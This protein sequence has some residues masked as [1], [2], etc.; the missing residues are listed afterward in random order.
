[1]ARFKRV[2]ILWL[3]VAV[4]AMGCAPS[5]PGGAPVSRDTQAQQPAPKRITAAVLGAPAMLASKM[6]GRGQRPAPGIDALEEL[7]HMG[8]WVYDNRGACCAHATLAESIPSVENGL[9]KV[10]PDG[11]MET[12]WKIKQGVLWHDGTPFTA[13][14]LRFTLTAVRDRDVEAHW[15]DPAFDWIE[16]VEAPDARTV[17]LRWERPFIFADSMFSRFYAYP[18]PK[19][20]LEKV[21]VEDKANFP[22]IR[23]WSSEFIGLGPFKL[24]EWA[25]DSHAILEA[26][27]RY[28]LGRP[29]IDKIEV[30]FIGDANTMVANILAG[31]IDVTLSKGLSLEQS[32]VTRDQWKDGTLYTMPTN[33]ASLYPQLIDPNPAVISDVRFRRALFHALDRQTMAD[34]LLGL[35]PSEGIVAHSHLIPQGPEYEAL[36]PSIVQYDYDPRKA[37]QIIEGLGYSKGA[38]GFYRDA[39]GEVLWAE[40]RADASIDLRDKGML[41]VVDQ[42]RRIGV[43]A[44]SL[45]IPRGRS[46]DR[47]WRATYPGFELTTIIRDLRSLDSLHSSNV[48][49]PEN[50]WIGSGVTRYVNPELDTLITRHVTTVPKP[51]RLRL[52]AQIYNHITDQVIF[53]PLFYDV[54]AV[55]GSNRLVNM[56]SYATDATQAWNGHEWDLK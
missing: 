39:A 40:V 21:F 55:L 46:S 18:L 22:N 12:T 38:D 9:W 32:L 31:Q 25:T 51:E 52:G 10:F 37:T 29:K 30:R 15:Y 5:Q 13:D 34:S 17:T 16:G 45:A 48:R 3:A 54:Q 20:V 1:M 47:E 8:L 56:E 27:D 42:W 26:Y 53:M 24:R 6:M 14:D 2:A 28:V 49:R 7:V 4:T 43:R 23:Y 44:E 35:K 19:H 36:R 50:N 11:R 41:T 33:A